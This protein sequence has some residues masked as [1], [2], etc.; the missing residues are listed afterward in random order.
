MSGATLRRDFRAPPLARYEIELS[1]NTEPIL[2]M[3]QRADGGLQW[4]TRTTR[5]EL[6]AGAG[7]RR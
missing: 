1:W 3:G 2:R 4:N 6:R 5:P 7:R